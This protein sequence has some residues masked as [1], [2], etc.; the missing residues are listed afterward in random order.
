MFPRKFLSIFFLFFFSLTVSAEFNEFAVE[1]QA[2]QFV[3]KGEP[4]LAIEWAV[5]LKKNQV[6]V[7][8][9]EEAGVTLFGD[10]LLVATRAG[11]LHFYFFFKSTSFIFRSSFYEQHSYFS[12]LKD[13]FPFSGCQLYSTILPLIR[14]LEGTTFSIQSRGRNE[15][16]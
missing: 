1:G 4:H 14:Y 9:R 11:E 13:V 7:N 8:R 6:Q 5:P 2:P 3:K 15:S 16:F 10:D 12:K